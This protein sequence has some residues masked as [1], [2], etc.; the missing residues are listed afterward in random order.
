MTSLSTTALSITLSA[1]ETSGSVYVICR[2]ILIVI[3]AAWFS[4]G[5]ELTERALVPIRNRLSVESVLLLD[6]E[7]FY[8]SKIK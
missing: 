3:A 2:D 7:D 4:P 5:R 8:D 6:K 1:A